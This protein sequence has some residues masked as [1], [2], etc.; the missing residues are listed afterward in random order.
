MILLLRASEAVTLTETESTS[1]VARGQQGGEMGMCLMATEFHFP[2]VKRV[3]EI[4][5]ITLRI[6]FTLLNC[7]LKNRW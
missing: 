5:G 2:K 1:V 3:L 4:R 6:Y 7:T